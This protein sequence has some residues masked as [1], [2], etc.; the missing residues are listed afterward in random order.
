MKNR[1]HSDDG[2]TDNKNTWMMSFSSIQTAHHTHIQ[3]AKTQHATATMHNNSSYSWT[4][5]ISVRLWMIDKST[6]MCSCIHNNEVSNKIASIKKWWWPTKRR[7]CVRWASL[8]SICIC[9]CWTHT[10]ISIRCVECGRRNAKRWR[11]QFSGTIAFIYYGRSQ[12]IVH[13]IIS[14]ASISLCR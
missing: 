9:I 5:Q 2:T 10:Y 7:V 3:R 13:K 12:P 14:F 6:R 4:R 8:G 11:K 1:Y